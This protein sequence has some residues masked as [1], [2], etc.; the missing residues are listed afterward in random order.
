MLG[1]FT[2][3][4]KG[5]QTSGQNS[6]SPVVHFAEKSNDLFIV[7]AEQ[8][9]KRG[10]PQAQ[11]DRAFLKTSL[12]SSLKVGSKKELPLH[13]ITELASKEST[14]RIVSQQI[15]AQISHQNKIYGQRVD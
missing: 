4:E 15:K 5:P 13:R 6:A 14:K 11:K 3:K 10:Q 7:K 1:G 9:I 8:T 12:K 2:I